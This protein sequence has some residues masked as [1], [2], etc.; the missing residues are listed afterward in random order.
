MKKKF[1]KVISTCLAAIMLLSTAAVAPISASAAQTLA[2]STGYTNGDFEYEILYGGTARITDYTG[3]ATE[4]TIPSEID[5]KKVTSI[6]ECA[7][8]GCTSLESV[9]IPDS[10]TEI[11]KYAFYYCT[12]LS[13]IN[14]DGGNAKYLSI[15]GV[16]FDKEARTLLAY[17]EGKKDS[18]YSIPDSVTE[19]GKYAFYR[20]TSLT[21]VMIPDSVTGIG[22]FAFYRCT[23]LTSVTIPDSVIEIG[24]YAFWDCTSLTSI[25]I[26][27]SVT[28]IGY[29]AFE[30]CTSLTSVIIPASVNFIGDYAF[31]YNYG[32]DYKPSKIDGFTITGYKGTAAQIYASDNGFEFISLGEA[33]TNPSEKVL[34]GDVNGDGKV[35]IK[36]ATMIQKSAA[37]LVTLTDEQ[38]KAADVNKDSKVNVNDTTAIQ[39]FVAGIDTG[40]DIGK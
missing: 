14:V 35:N 15:D 4:L 36:D 33:P 6:G 24:N 5:G 10:V 3:S 13:S 1:R 27:D 23:S 31:G 38:A 32:D 26:P 9:T 18:V 34:L 30:N 2:V 11:D 8:Y 21:S 37:S 28:S 12:S 25:T 19:I 22:D 40:L 17:P 7:F 20:C 39:R 16:L 29:G